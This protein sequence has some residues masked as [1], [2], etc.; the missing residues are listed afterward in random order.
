[1]TAL[2]IGIRLWIWAAMIRVLKRVVPI[3]TLV[4]LARGQ[5]GVRPGSDQGPFARSDEK[6]EERL[7]AYLESKGRFPFRPPSNCL[8]RSLGVYRLLCGVA[9]DPELVVGVRRSPERGV[10]GHVWVTARGHV[11]A[12]RPEEL[13]TFTPIVTF[14]ANGRQRTA[15]GFEGALSEIPVP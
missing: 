7:R 9:G 6:L 13:S 4:R 10:E 11:L 12:E 8:E 2:G 5:T 3:G 14:D 15:A 1:V